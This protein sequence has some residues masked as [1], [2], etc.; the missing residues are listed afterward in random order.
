MTWGL[1]RR[2]DRKPLEMILG[3]LPRAVGEQVSSGGRRNLRRFGE[4]YAV[5]VWA[6][7]QDRSPSE[8]Q[9]EPVY[10]PSRSRKP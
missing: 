6:G 7:S 5:G 1:I 2:E 8:A 3:F 9:P 10:S 4:V